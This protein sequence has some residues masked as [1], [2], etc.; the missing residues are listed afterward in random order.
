LSFEAIMLCRA[1]LARETSMHAEM[2]GRF[3]GGPMRQ[4]VTSKPLGPHSVP[5]KWPIADANLSPGA[6][7][8]GR[9]LYSTGKI[10][11]TSSWHPK[12]SDPLQSNW[13]ELILRDLIR[14]AEDVDADS[15]IRLD[16]QNDGALRIDETGVKLTRIDAT[17]IVVMLSC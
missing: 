13:Q 16:Y 12:G 11:A 9:V 8:G 2:I 14:K 4:P 7:E 6:I 15:I 1:R 5:V 3:C 10:E 17:G